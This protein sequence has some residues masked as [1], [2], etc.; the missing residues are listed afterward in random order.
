MVSNSAEMP[1]NWAH[2]GWLQPANAAKTNEK[3]AKLRMAKF[4]VKVVRF[5]HTQNLCLGVKV[6]SIFVPFVES[7]DS[8]VD[9]PAIFVYLCK[10]SD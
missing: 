2:V 4:F 10:V 5:N 1:V 6:A 9:F 3:S 7:D 8:F